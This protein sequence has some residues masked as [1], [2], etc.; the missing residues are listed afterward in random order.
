MKIKDFKFNKHMYI[1]EYTPIII[2]NTKYFGITYLVHYLR[3]ALENLFIYKNNNNTN[4]EEKMDY[5]IERIQKTTVTYHLQF[6]DTKY[7][8]EH[9]NDILNSI[10]KDIQKINQELYDILYAT[11]NQPLRNYTKNLP[12]IENDLSYFEKTT[13]ARYESTYYDIKNKL[14][15]SFAKKFD[16]IYIQ[17]KSESVKNWYSYETHTRHKPTKQIKYVIPFYRYISRDVI[18]FH[19]LQFLRYD[20]H[21]HKYPAHW[22][23]PNSYHYSPKEYNNEMQKIGE[24]IRLRLQR[25]ALFNIDNNY[26][27]INNKYYLYKGKLI[28]VDYSLYKLNEKWLQEAEIIKKCIKL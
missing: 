6:L 22:H 17:D 14:G 4:V 8:L 18:T 21:S 5:A 15:P 7:Y 2:K 9:L 23:R 1:L 10:P 25:N 13:Y 26:Q 11:I 28:D 16:Y 27:I 24:Y 20:L 3:Y 19:I 12:I